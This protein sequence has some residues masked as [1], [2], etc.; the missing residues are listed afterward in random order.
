MA[1]E[2]IESLDLLDKD[3]ELLIVILEKIKN[4]IGRW[5]DRKD[6]IEKIKTLIESSGIFSYRREKEKKYDSPL[7][8]LS[9]NK[10]KSLEKFGYKFTYDDKKKNR[11]DDLSGD[12]NFVN[13]K[14]FELIISKFSDYVMEYART[15]KFKELFHG[16]DIS[17]ELLDLDLFSGICSTVFRIEISV[18]DNI[19]YL[20]YVSI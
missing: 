15:E 6:V 3:D 14:I 11:Q 18:P 2:L 4:N 9:V 16:L 7:F 8:I 10:E 19:I 13:D 1:T 17:E 5:M 12:F 20:E